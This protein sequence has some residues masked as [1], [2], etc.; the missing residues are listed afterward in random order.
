M[1]GRGVS[2]DAVRVAVRHRSSE[3]GREEG[4]GPPPP[5]PTPSSFLS[6]PEERDAEKRREKEREEGGRREEEMGG[7]GCYVGPFCQCVKWQCFAH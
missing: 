2:L 6:P 3:R 4:W 5:P 7:C 1:H